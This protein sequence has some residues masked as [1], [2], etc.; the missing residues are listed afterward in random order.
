MQYTLNETRNPPN[1]GTNQ[2]QSI[3]KTKTS[4]TSDTHHRA[5]FE[6]LGLYKHNEYDGHVQ[7]RKARAK[8]IDRKRKI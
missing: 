4:D 6:L 5:H 8:P 3:E 1:S 7:E 2:D